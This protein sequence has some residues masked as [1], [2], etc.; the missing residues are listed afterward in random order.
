M[1]DVDQIHR[2]INEIVSFAKALDALADEHAEGKLTDDQFI[3]ATGEVNRVY[4][5]GK[6]DG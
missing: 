3:D 1:T 6:V 4:N 2:E 5:E